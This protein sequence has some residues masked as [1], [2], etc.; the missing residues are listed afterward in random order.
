[1]RETILDIAQE[2]IQRR[3]INGMSYNDISKAVEI[4]KASIHHHFPSKEALINAVLIRYRAEFQESLTEILHASVKP[5]TKLQRFMSLFESTIAHGGNDKACLCG[6]LSAELLS[7]SEETAELVREFL[8]DCRDAIAQILKEGQ[9]DDSFVI[10]GNIK[11]MSDL[12]L[13]TLEGGLF[14]ARVEG[15]PERFS[16]LLRQ[17]E[18]TIC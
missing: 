6:M 15:G 10:C 9:E 1:M 4:R 11:N 7:L 13:A 16:K 5:K 17:L 14:M 3:G 2:L 8:N 18:K 12:F